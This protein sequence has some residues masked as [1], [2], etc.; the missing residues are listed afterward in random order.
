LSPLAA[1][2]SSSDQQQFDFY[3]LLTVFSVAAAMVGVCLTAIGLVKVVRNQSQVATVCDALLVGDAI[4]F[5]TA[6]LLSFLA[7][8]LRFRGRWRTFALSADVS[9]LIAMV[10]MVFCCVVWVWSLI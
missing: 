8:R 9:I 10:V 2:H 5:L 3:H 7:M 1:D 4:L 6:M